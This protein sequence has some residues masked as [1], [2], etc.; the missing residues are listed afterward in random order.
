MLKV[1]DVVAANRLAELAGHHGVVG[2]VTHVDD[3][4][5]VT[6]EVVW[7]EGWL[8]PA[9]EKEITRADIR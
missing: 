1:G 5:R 3:D 2:R 9:T 4:G 8:R 6:V 7:G